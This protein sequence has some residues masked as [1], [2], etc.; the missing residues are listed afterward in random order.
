MKPVAAIAPFSLREKLRKVFKGLVVARKK[1][2]GMEIVG[3]TCVL[4]IS[5]NVD[6]FAA[7]GENGWGKHG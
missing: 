3:D 4:G 7:F 2:S 1:V 5:T 6:N